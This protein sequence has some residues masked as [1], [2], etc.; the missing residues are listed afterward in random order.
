MDVSST[1]N[2]V[3]TRSAQQV[4]AYSDKFPKMP[5]LNLRWFWLYQLSWFQWTLL[6][7]FSTAL[8]IY[9]RYINLSSYERFI[10][11]IFSSTSQNVWSQTHRNISF[12]ITSKIRLLIVVLIRIG[13]VMISR[14]WFN[15]GISFFLDLSFWLF[16]SE[17]VGWFSKYRI[18][19]NK[20]ENI[21]F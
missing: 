2:K 19:E 7:V 12:R 17:E 3:L 15:E 20:M 13:I 16:L 14:V 6:V 21:F 1:L 18:G 5:F 4:H 9:S 8:L 10:S 11:L